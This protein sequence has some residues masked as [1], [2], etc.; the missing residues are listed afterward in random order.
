MFYNHSRGVRPLK[1]LHKSFYQ[2]VVFSR[3]DLQQVAEFLCPVRH[4]LKFQDLIVQSRKSEV[5]RKIIFAYLMMTS[6]YAFIFSLFS[7]NLQSKYFWGALKLFRKQCLF[8][9][10]RTSR[11]K[12][13][14]ISVLECI[15]ILILLNL[16]AN[17]TLEKTSSQ[18]KIII[19]CPGT[20]YNKKLSRTSRVLP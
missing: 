3:D 18:K 9:M 11:Y 8:K 6:K 16:S 17:Y 4:N 13:Q 14:W 7:D 15:Y 5:R 12:N 10:S 19:Y 2:N 1:T 20:S